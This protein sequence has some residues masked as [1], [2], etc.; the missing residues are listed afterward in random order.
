[1]NRAKFVVRWKDQDG[2]DRRREYDKEP[3]ARKAR[4]WL[5]ANGAPTADVA[6][7]MGEREYASTVK[8]EESS[9]FPGAQPVQGNLL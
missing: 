9:M 7:K 5:I 3:E 2:N 6:V 1:M 8:T 4:D